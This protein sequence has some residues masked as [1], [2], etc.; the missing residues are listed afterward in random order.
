MSRAPSGKVGRQ[1]VS[2][3]SLPVDFVPLASS[4]TG[5]GHSSQTHSIVHLSPGAA[6][7]MSASV[8]EPTPQLELKAPSTGDLS[9]A[10]VPPA[11]MSTQR[12]RN[13]D[14][15]DYSSTDVSPEESPSEGLGSF[16][17]GSYQRLGENSSMT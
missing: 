17:P 9:T 8:S 10:S 2:R 16:S 12:L 3:P 14:Y 7:T 15:H 6:V 5:T 13:E 1:R 4:L 11:T